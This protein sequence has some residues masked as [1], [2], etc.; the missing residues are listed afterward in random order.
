MAIFIPKPSQIFFFG[1]V[2]KSPIHIGL[3]YVKNPKPNISCL[4]PFKTCG[5]GVAKCKQAAPHSSISARHPYF[6][7]F[8]VAF[9][10]RSF[11]LSLSLGLP[12]TI[13][14]IWTERRSKIS[15]TVEYLNNRSHGQNFS[16]KGPKHDQ[17][18]CGFFY[19]NQTSMGR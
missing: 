8:A 17:I 15:P 16:L 4:G 1:L 10:L 11:N 14:V 5:C 9:H 18:E 7:Y 13:R 2:P 12:P 3:I 6:L 19:L